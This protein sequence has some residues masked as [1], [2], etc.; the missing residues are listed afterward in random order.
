MPLANENTPGYR[1]RLVRFEELLA[2]E[3]ESMRSSRPGGPGPGDL[4]RLLRIEPKVETDEASPAS[5]DGNNVN[6]E[7]E[8]NAMR[9]NRLL[10][11]LYASILATRNRMIEDS[12]Q[13]GR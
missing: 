8:M 10:Y 11:E 5:P 9:E 7:L 3:L 4:E 1:R 6:L 13:S 12:I 2:S